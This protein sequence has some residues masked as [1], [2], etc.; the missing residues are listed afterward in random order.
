MNSQIKKFKKKILAVS[1]LEYKGPA[2]SSLSIHL[3][4]TMMNTLNE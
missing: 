1:F 3:L 4:S 2:L